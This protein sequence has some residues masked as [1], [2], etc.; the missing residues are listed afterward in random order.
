MHWRNKMKIICILRGYVFAAVASGL[1]V[2]ACAAGNICTWTGLGGDG[3]WST[4]ANWDVAPVSGNEDVIVFEGGQVISY[5]DMSDFSVAGIRCTGDGMK[6][7]NGETIVLTGMPFVA[8]NS[9]G[10]STRSYTFSNSC[11]TVYNVDLDF[12]QNARILAD[13]GAVSTTFNGNIFVR[14]GKTLYIGDAFAKNRDVNTSRT[15]YFNG[16]IDAPEGTVVWSLWTSTGYIN[17]AVDVLN[18]NF[19]YSRSDMHL[20]VFSGGLR[21]RS[22]LFQIW[23][24]K[25]RIRCDNLFGEYLPVVDWSNAYYDNRGSMSSIYLDGHTL[26]IDRFGSTAIYRSDSIGNAIHS[27]DPAT[28]I[29]KSTADSSTYGIISGDV[30]LVFDPNDSSRVLEFKSRTSSTTGSLLVKSGTFRII[31]AAAFP[32][33]SSIKLENNAVFEMS[34]TNTVV[35]PLNSLKVLKLEESARFTVAPGT[36]SPCFADNSIILKLKSSSRLILPE[37]FSQTAI[38]CYI[39]G[40]P[41]FP[42][43]YTGQ[44]GTSGTQVDFI[45]GAGTLVIEPG[46]NITAWSGLA[47][48]GLWITPGN[49]NN[50]VPVAG[51]TV[52]IF[53]DGETSVIAPAEITAD[54]LQLEADYGNVAL[55]VDSDIAINGTIFDIGTNSSFVVDSDVDVSYVSP[56]DADSDTDVIYVHDGGTVKLSGTFVSSN[57]YGRISVKNGGKLHIDDADINIAPPA[58]KANSEVLRVEG[59]TLSISNSNIVLGYNFNDDVNK[60]N[61][62]TFYAYGGSSVSIHNTYLRFDE[63]IWGDIFGTGTA[64]L[65]GDTHLNF[66]KHVRFSFS[67]DK[68][69]E[70]CLVYMR[71][72]SKISGAQEMA[73]GNGVASSRSILILDS[74]GAVVEKNSGCQIGCTAGYAEVE[75][76]QGTFNGGS[77]YGTHIGYKTPYV[78]TLSAIN[79]FFPTGVVKVT[80]GTFIPAG[81]AN[82]KNP[83]G[84]IL[85]DGIPVSTAEKVS[86]RFTGILELSEGIVSNM[87]SYVILGLMHGSGFVNQTG[88]SFISS[89]K[90][91]AMIGFAGGSGVWN[92]SAGETKFAMNVYIGGALTN[93]LNIGRWTHPCFLSR[94]DAKGTLNVSGG[95]FTVDDYDIILSMDGEGEISLSGEGIVSARDLILSNTVDTVNSVTRTSTMKFI[96]DE[97]GNAGKINLSGKLVIGEGASLVCDTGTYNGRKSRFKLVEAN[98]ITGSFDSENITFLG[99]SAKI[100]DIRTTETTV[101]LVIDRGFI[102]SIK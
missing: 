19:D 38:A 59:S 52:S 46:S 27:D 42:G 23:Y 53:K 58:I 73:V 97:Y 81:Q 63:W 65:S 74:P 10:N 96:L 84:L 85:G 87:T 35:R 91:P 9:S 39:D 86:S 64:V 17:G 93:A 75:I 71:D 18:Y 11:D 62:C 32:N 57:L 2:V 28:L 21:I 55:H 44:G 33:L 26:T 36:E 6:T 45:E 12:S 4:A 5:N 69:N 76:R 50:G 15:F 16:R 29:V 25:P 83:Y 67:A 100:A 77:H 56:T 95:T 40:N 66:H 94:H 90:Q 101:E 99:D 98:S 7:F 13:P 70:E 8:P 54:K 68:A 47:N 72:N 48:D 1:A 34:S 43:T 49:W 88:G 30:S 80:G 41:L 31:D 89:A 92:Q 78:S 20:P 14:A 51:S 22:G 37:G 82:D 79:S 24:V 3:K 60:G 61:D 102:L